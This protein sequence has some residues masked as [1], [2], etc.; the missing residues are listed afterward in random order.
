MAIENLN[1]KHM[2]LATLFFFLIQALFFT[3]FAK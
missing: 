1:K 2:I 3:S